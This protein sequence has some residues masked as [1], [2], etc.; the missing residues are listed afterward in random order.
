MLIGLE[1]GPSAVHFALLR[2]QHPASRR[3]YRRIA[4]RR[5]P[6]WDGRR[7]NSGKEEVRV[8]LIETLLHASQFIKPRYLRPLSMAA[9]M[10]SW[11][12]HVP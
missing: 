12:V 4:L 7:V 2:L 6:A 3:A 5:G 8:L 10:V 9:S 1:N 11:S